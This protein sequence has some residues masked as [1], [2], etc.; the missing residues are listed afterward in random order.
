M[1]ER[2]VSYLRLSVT[3]RCNLRCSYCMGPDGVPSRK[4][5]EILTYE[6]ILRV[7]AAAIPMGI[8]RFR[9]T[10][11][12]PLVRRGVVSLVGRLAA[13]AGVREVTMTSN[14]LLLPDLAIPL[15]EAG[16]SRVN[17]SLDSLRPDVY[18]TLT[19]G[20][21]LAGALAG[22]AAALRAG[23]SPVKLNVVLVKGMN[24]GEVEDFAAL[25]ATYALAVRFIELM[26]LGES[27]SWASARQVPGPAVLARLARRGRLLP[28]AG[29][30]GNG[31]A[32]YYRWIPRRPVAAPELP[33]VSPAGDGTA[34]LGLISALS[35]PFCDTC[36]RLRLTADGKLHGCLA[37][38]DGIDLREVLRRGAGA[39]ELGRLFTLAIGRKPLVHG[40]D[41]GCGAHRR[42]SELGG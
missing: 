42:M 29:V 19:R 30:P 20:G 11:G 36:N 33:G 24:D 6:E 1:S 12:E 37:Q 9:V 8:D 40:M 3:D 2:K 34:T 39:E 15:R 23:L 10:G 38:E 28:L 41:G 7:A 32:V 25:A 31:P 13:L 18:R 21:S 5:E 14:G 26:P 35:R 27:H 4:H 16:L 17:L 22:L